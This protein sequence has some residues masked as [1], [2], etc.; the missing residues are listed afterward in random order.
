MVVLI[1]FEIMSW[2]NVMMLVN[3]FFTLFAIFGIKDLVSWAS[4]EFIWASRSFVGC[5][6]KIRYDIVSCM[7]FRIGWVFNWNCVLVSSFLSLLC[8]VLR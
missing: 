5:L 7:R 3:S 8:I 2:A 6:C 1:A 4:W